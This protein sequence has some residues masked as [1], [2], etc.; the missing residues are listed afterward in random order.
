MERFIKILAILGLAAS[1][2]VAQPV[3]WASSVDY[4]YNQFGTEE[5]SGQSAVGAPDAFP[6]GFINPKAYRLKDEKGFG[7]I[8]LSFAKPAPI[9]QLTIVESYAPGRITKISLLDKEGNKYPIYIKEAKAL[10]LKFRTLMINI[11]ETYYS[12][13]KVEI[14]VDTEA[15]EGWA[16]IDA[17][18]VSNASSA[19]DI[20]VYLQEKYGR[21][22]VAD[23]IFFTTS[24][25]NLGTTVNSQ[26]PE[27]KPIISADGKTLYF[28][29]QN[30]DGN[31]GG[32]SDDQDIYVSYLENGT[33]SEAENIGGPLNDKFA[34]GVC[35][36]SP[37]GNTLLL[38]NAYSEEGAVDRGVSIS[39]KTPYG[40]EA[41]APV[42]IHD[43]AAKGKYLDFYMSA[44]EE[45]IIIAYQAK[46]SG[47]GDQDL[48]VSLKQSG[49]AY[50][51][52]RNLGKVINTDKAEFSPF[53]APDNKTLYFASNGHGGMGGSDVFYTKRLDESWTNW[54]TPVNLGSNIN[55]ADWDGYYS[56]SADGSKAFFTSSDEA[57][58]GA[59]DIYS[60][61]LENEL[62]P[63]PVMMVRGR[64]INGETNEPIVAD[65]IFETYFDGKKEAMA[66]PNGKT[67]EYKAILSRGN[68]YRVLAYAEGYVPAD[69]ELDVPS[70]DSYTE[71]TKDIV[72]DPIALGDLITFNNILFNQST[73]DL[74]PG[75]EGDLAKLEML[76]R[77]N[78]N[79]VVELAGHTDSWGDASK[80]FQLS[81]ARVQVIKSTLA[82]RGIDAARLQVKGYGG[83]KPVASNATEET[84]QMNRRVEVKILKNQ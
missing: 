30:S 45:A 17:V 54:S 48:Y 10:E 27:A 75:A 64:V 49:E 42:F 29:R 66:S 74:L 5:Y 50:S 8:M 37:D 19:A 67:M 9:Q 21:L 16:Q 38:M 35:S 39:R 51:K 76:L 83:S 32:Q 70:F 14:V 82:M 18:G 60:I 72:L 6:L 34:N 59:R 77:E 84:R 26:F 1:Q 31:V 52:P 68:K 80:N 43:F 56:I 2:A 69:V 4:L 20:K 63:E 44:S 53:L 36:V 25:E 40:W 79:M 57:S 12:V 23:E 55:T 58:I 41:P 46:E 78:P 22:N 24:K 7:T 11:P 81:L 61:S 71:M 15:I 73:P 62:K 47:Y 28:A 13:E 33:W 65:I 3:Q